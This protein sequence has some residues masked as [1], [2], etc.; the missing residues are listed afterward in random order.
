MVAGLLTNQAWIDTVKYLL[1]LTNTALGFSSPDA[2]QLP[3]RADVCSSSAASS[4]REGH[5]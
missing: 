3:S 4:T 5:G 2:I 1:L